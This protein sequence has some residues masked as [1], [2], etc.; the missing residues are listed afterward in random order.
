MSISG[1]KLH[2]NTLFFV[3]PET[4]A[5]KCNELRTVRQGIVY[6]RGHL[7]IERLV[8][9][10]S[11]V[12]R[13]LPRLHQLHLYHTTDAPSLLTTASG[14]RPGEHVIVN[15]LSSKSLNQAICSSTVEIGE[16]G[17]NQFKR[18]ERGCYTSSANSGLFTTHFS[19]LYLPIS[20]A[21]QLIN[22]HVLQLNHSSMFLH[23]SLG[24][25]YLDHHSTTSPLPLSRSSINSSIA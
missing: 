23:F 1:G 16:S 24:A 7:A 10:F 6:L 3:A 14:R 18:A 2:F 21:I 11:S 19:R 13:F 12:T 9:H 25:S 15:L 17:F 4:E 20:K 22:R 5:L 8:M